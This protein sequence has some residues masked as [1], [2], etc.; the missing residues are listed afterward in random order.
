MH[1]T[2][3]FGRMIE[4]IR[5]TLKQ[6][7]TSKSIICFMI[8]KSVACLAQASPESTLLP[9][10]A[11]VMRIYREIQPAGEKTSLWWSLFSLP[12]W[13]GLWKQWFQQI[14][15]SK[16]CANLKNIKSNLEKTFTTEHVF[17]LLEKSSGMLIL[18]NSWKDEQVASIM[19]S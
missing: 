14:Q 7:K 15:D 17:E 2:S 10:A 12:L 3:M 8:F 16:L 9:V 18:K 5:T 19:T 11:Q 1:A 13:R 6:K 4:M